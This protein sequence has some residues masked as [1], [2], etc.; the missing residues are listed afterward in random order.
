MILEWEEDGSHRLTVNALLDTGCTTPLLSQACADRFRIPRVHREEK[1]GL[2]NFAGDLVEGAGEAYSVPLLLRHKQHYTKEV[3]EIAPLE[4]GVDLFLPFWW[5]VKHAPQGAWDSASLRF[6]SDSCQ[7]H[8]TREAASAFALQLDPDILQHPEARVIGYVSAVTETDDIARVPVQFRPFLDIMGKE[9]ADALPK[10]RSYDHEIRLKEGETAPWGPIYPLSEVEL[11]TLREWLKDMLRTG[12][13]RRS[14]SSVS[15]PIL[16][17]PKP[18][19]RGLRLCVDYRGLNRVTIANRY[20]LPLMSELQDRIRGAQFFTKIDLKNG[21]HLVR[22]K[23]G[24]EWK[25]AFRTRYGLYEFLVMPFGLCNAPA[26]FQDMINHIFRDLLDQGLVAYIDDLLIYASTREKHDQIVTEVLKRLRDNRLAVSAEK[27]EW[28]KEEVE[29]LGYVIGRDGVKM[30]QEKVEGVLEWKTPKSLVEVQ[31]F[32]GFANFYRRFIRDYSRIA[33]PLTELTKGDGKSW[34]WT[35]EAEQAFTELKQRFT[36]APILAHFDPTRPVIVES[37]ASDFALGAV[38][39]QRDSDNRLHPV[40]FHSRKFSPAEINYEIHDKE[41][42]AIVDSFKHWRRYLEGAAHQV[43]VFSDHQN[44]EYFTTTKVLNRRQAR[45]AQ[46]LA[47][48]DFKIFYRPG[49]KNGKPDALSRRPEYRPEKGG[50]EDQ[51]ITTV[52]HPRH[53]GSTPAAHF[54]STSAAHPGPTPAA[55][56]S[57]FIIS[58]ARMGSIPAVRWSADFLG[59]VKE[60]AK[61]DIEYGKAEALVRLSGKDGRKEGEGQEKGRT[62]TDGILESREGCVYRKERL[63]VPEGKGLRQG[64]LESEHDTKVAG[65]MGQDKT[66]ELIRRNFW[67]P[68]MDE[69]IID[70]VRSCP[71]C[72]R[73]KAA[74]HQ[75]YGLLNPLELPY[76]PWQSIAMDF[77]TDLPLSEGCDQLWV[78]IDRFTKMAHFIALPT[79]GKTASDL[80]RIFAREVWKYHGLPA[81]IVS[82]RDSRFTSEVWKEFLRMSGIRSRMSTAFH[83]QTDG[84]TERLNQTIEAYLRSFV[85][86]EQDDWVNLLPMAEFAYNNS[87]TTATG[88][89]PFYANYGFHP[90]AANPSSTGPLNPASK[91]Y[92]HWMRSV[93]EEVTK[94]LEATRER[95]RRYADLHRKDPPLYR[96][97]DLVMLNGR[98]IQTR[99]PSRKLD[100][101]NHGPFQVEKIVSPLAVKLTLPRKWKIHDVFHVSLVEPFRVGSRETPDP[102]KVL[103]EADNIENSEEYDVDEVMASI[104]KGRRV[105]YLVKWLDYPDRRDWTKEPFDNF[106]VGGLEKL[107][108]FHRANPDAPRDYRLTEG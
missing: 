34:T 12:K 90:T 35:S 1:V 50:D 15:S 77:I 23:E 18:H 95:T 58:A 94:S 22:I 17:V 61:E 105:L 86:Y 101:K 73:N 2:R 84:Q 103:R 11:E 96:V 8:C 88:L 21:Y 78:V 25:T 33:R 59:L 62:W 38:L 89:S 37:D 45:W 68:K 80:A 99:R 29:F 13:I 9:A 76:A 67:W 107:R 83:P 98:N 39:S 36:T 87:V 20:P 72:Q 6:N 64:I 81:D 7:Q 74:R 104:K 106:S 26:T 4:P 75:P 49:V 82:D 108:E 54:E 43:Q 100:H 102:S 16:F 30:S 51:P 5:I 46:E 69:D 53:F 56:G 47:G 32:L 93:Q 97:G 79:N 40:A 28:A 42:L 10:H 44:L 60:A 31:Q 52:L 70:F 63:W 91:V 48:I 3:F 71:E 92:A 24:D 85:N 65:H 41:L 27:C 66:I 14:T 57:S 55:T 19:G